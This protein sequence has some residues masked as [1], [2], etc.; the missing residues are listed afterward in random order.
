[1]TTTTMREI[2]NRCLPMSASSASPVS[3]VKRH[4]QHPRANDRYLPDG[5]STCII[6]L[7]IRARVS[8]PFR[9]ERVHHRQVYHS[10][11]L[12]GDA[13]REQGFAPPDL[14]DFRLAFG[15]HAR[16]PAI[17]Q[18]HLGINSSCLSTR[19]ANT[20]SKPYLS[21]R[22]R[23]VRDRGDSAVYVQ[24]FAR[25]PVFTPPRNDN[26]G[27]FHRNEDFM[28]GFRGDATFAVDDAAVRI[29]RLTRLSTLDVARTSNSQITNGKYRGRDYCSA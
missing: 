18:R 24:A 1:M 7:V 3:S 10:F 6:S 12:L 14:Y 27:D 26:L 23:I 15:Q 29:M 22:V 9:K 5:A 20:A 13:L 28:N 19:H 4:R 11:S 17:R 16:E 25:S 21:F 2:K 8:R